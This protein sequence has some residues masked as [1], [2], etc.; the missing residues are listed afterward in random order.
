MTLEELNI[1]EER[2]KQK[3]QSVNL[4]IPKIPTAT[5]GEMSEDAIRARLAKVVTVG[6]RAHSEAQHAQIIAELSVATNIPK[7]HAERTEFTGEQWLK[8]KAQIAEKIGTGF[9]F[10]LI[11]LRGAGKTQIGV[12]VIRESV[13]RERSAEYTTAMDIFLDIKGSFNRDAHITEAQTV[14]SFLKPKLL[15]IDE[16]QERAESAWEDRILTHIINKR[17]ND[18]KDT[19]L[20]G[21]I[22]PGTFLETMGAS[23]VSRLNETGG[24]IECDWESFRK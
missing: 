1:L 9:L 6:E 16:I 13:N 14:A 18:E 8:R 20:I 2:R 7:R 10:A 11:G 21:N 19:L 23:V 4:G 15:V 22:K 17:Y 12:E 24:I 5:A 3:A